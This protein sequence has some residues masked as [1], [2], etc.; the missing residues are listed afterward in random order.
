MTQELL[1]FDCKSTGLDFDNDEVL[2]LA[3]IDTNGEV[4]LNEL[5][6]PLRH[7]QWPGAQRIHGISPQM[8]EGCPTLDDITARLENLVRGR[9]LV[10]YN[11]GFDVD[12]LQGRLDGAGRVRCAMVAFADVMA[13]PASDQ[14]PLWWKL[15]DAARYCDHQWEQDS[16]HRA[17]GDAR[18]TLSVWRRLH[19]LDADRFPLSVQERLNHC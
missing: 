1:I 17:L 12:M 11:A 14:E 8:V 10:I 13:D 19:A 7:T 16:A 9:D 15:V 4:L 5:V 3:L 6:R 18:A 2:E